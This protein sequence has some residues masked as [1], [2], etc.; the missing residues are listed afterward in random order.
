MAPHAT[1][2]ARAELRAY[3]QDYELMA[4]LTNTTATKRQHLATDVSHR[5]ADTVTMHSRTTTT[6][7][8]NNNNLNR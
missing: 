3:N 7:N 4:E 1:E 2:R 5:G 8:N 6:E